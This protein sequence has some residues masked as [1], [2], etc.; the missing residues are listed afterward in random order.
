[1]RYRALTPSPRLVPPH[2]PVGYG[3]DSR[4]F[5]HGVRP[6]GP[7]S[8]RRGAAAPVCHPVR[9]RSAHSKLVR[10]P[11]LLSA[12]GKVM[13]VTS[14]AVQLHPSGVFL[15]ATCEFVQNQ[16]QVVIEHVPLY[17][18]RSPSLLHRIQQQCTAVQGLVEV[19][20]PNYGVVKSPEVQEILTKLV[21]ALDT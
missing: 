20:D 12:Q 3:P 17:L 19:W 13:A 21:E 10:R 5:P 7:G 14:V 4:S 16:Q 18:A 11:L 1:M 2:P 9:V 15:T 6:I 8:W